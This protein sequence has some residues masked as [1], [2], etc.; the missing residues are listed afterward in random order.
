MPKRKAR[1]ETVV[2]VKRQ[3][4][5]R[6]K[7]FALPLEDTA[8]TAIENVLACCEGSPRVQQK[9]ISKA[10]F[11]LLSSLFERVDIGE[12]EKLDWMRRLGDAE[13]GLDKLATKLED[14]LKTVRIELD[15]L[16]ERLSKEDTS[17]V[18]DDD[19]GKD[20]SGG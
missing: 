5:D 12:N 3:T 1:D 11:E 17:R 9:Q 6:L 18:G 14:Q 10:R 16:R 13:N 8:N 15:K 19:G 2:R 7:Q 20:G 4:I